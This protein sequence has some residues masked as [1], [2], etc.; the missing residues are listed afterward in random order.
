[1]PI[2]QIERNNVYDPNPY[3]EGTEEYRA[4][5]VLNHPD[6]EEYPGQHD[7]ERE[8]LRKVEE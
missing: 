7:Y 3:E 1:M 8:V 2:E 6:G 4:W 5:E